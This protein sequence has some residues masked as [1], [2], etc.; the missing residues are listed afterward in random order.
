MRE[1][2]F[3]KKGGGQMKQYMSRKEAAQYTGLSYH[4]IRTGT[5]NGTIPYIMSGKKILVNVPRLL[6]QLDKESLK[7]KTETCRDL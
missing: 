2:E 7:P 3:D 6:E 5:D 1:I 4:F